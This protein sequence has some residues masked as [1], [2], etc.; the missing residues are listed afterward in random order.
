[1]Y[2][3][4]CYT[5]SRRRLSYL[6]WNGMQ[7]RLPVTLTQSPHGF[8]RTLVV[9]RALWV[10]TECERER[11]PGI[12]MV[13]VTPYSQ[14]IHSSFHVLATQESKSVLL[15]WQNESQGARL[16]SSLILPFLS[17]ELDRIKI[18]TN[19]LAPLGRDRTG[20]CMYVYIYFAATIHR[21]LW[22]TFVL[23]NSLYIYKSWYLQGKKHSV[24]SWVL[25][26]AAILS[27]TRCQF[28]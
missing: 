19:E 2:K 20:T 1:M 24:Q 15:S 5:V 7:L 4:L 28:F 13:V 26:E 6:E 25:E 23:W 21:T 12:W 11:R 16:I 18:G 17:S 14:G 10:L 3:Q 27:L 9:P 22:Q 8:W